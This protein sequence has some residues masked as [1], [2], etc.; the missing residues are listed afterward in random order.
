MRTLSFGISRV[1]KIYS[2]HARCEPRYSYVR[3]IAR[4]YEA[5]SIAK[6][7][8]RRFAILSELLAVFLPRGR[9]LAVPFP[10]LSKV[11][12][13]RDGRVHILHRDPFERAVWV[14]L[15]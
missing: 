8:G 15:T 12:A 13:G 11:S 3:F 7:R 9:N 4:L 10:Q 6:Q 5:D 2:C 14:A 1:A